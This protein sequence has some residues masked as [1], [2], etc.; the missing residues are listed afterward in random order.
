M[1]LNPLKS[2]LVI[3]TKCPRHKKQIDNLKSTVKLFGQDIPIIAEATFLGVIFDTRLTWGSQ[4]SKMTTKAYK[5]INILRHLASLCTKPN[6]NTLIHLYRSIIRPIF[7]YG[8]LCY[9]NAAEVHLEKLQLLQ[10]QALRVVMQSPKFTSIKDLHDCT[11]SSL[12]KDHLISDARH[13]LQTMRKNS[14]LI[15]NVMTDYQTVRHIHENA[16]PLD[17]LA[18]QR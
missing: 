8:S 1:A 14:P 6:P 5:R 13:R 17:I 2:Q 7:E 10:N 12:I 9:I 18:N 4:F 16:S 15:Q 3:Y 11:G